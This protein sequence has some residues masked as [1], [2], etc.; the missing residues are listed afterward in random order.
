MLLVASVGL[1]DASSYLEELVL[2]ADRLE[3]ASDPY[4]YKLLH[5]REVDS[6]SVRSAA[7]GEGFLLAEAGRDDP[8]AEL[9]ATLTSFFQ[10]PSEGQEQ[11]PQCRFIAR[12][13]WLDARLGFD[14]SKLPPHACPEFD[15][16]YRTIKPD[17]LTLVFAS[18]YVNNPASMYGHTLLRIDQPD[19]V[20]SGQLVAYAINYSASTA[21][22]NGIVFAVLGISG[23]Y[24]GE[25]S[26][27]PYYDKVK[28][29][30]DLE[31]R[32]LWEYELALTGAETD[33]ILR[34][35]WEL[36]GVG[37]RYYFF[38]QNCSYRLLELLEVARPGLEFTDGF[39]LWAIPTDTVRTVLKTE[40]ML[41]QVRFRPGVATKLRHQF[42][43]MPRSERELIRA[44]AVGERASDDAA[45]SNAPADERARILE[46]AYEYLRYLT[47]AGKTPREVAAPRLRSLLVARSRVPV[48]GPLEPPPAPAVRP[49][50][51]HATARLAVSGGSWDGR[52]FRAA[53]IRAAYHGLLDPQAG[54]QENAEINFFDFEVR[55]LLED[56]TTRLEQ[57]D[58]IRIESLTPRDLFFSPMSWNVRFGLVRQ[59]TPDGESPLVT[60]LDGG[61]A[62]A[63]R[64]G[65]QTGLIAYGGWQSLLQV[66]HDLPRSWRVGAGPR[67]GLLIDWGAFGRFQLDGHGLWLLDESRPQWRVSAEHRV[68]LTRSLAFGAR[69]GRESVFDDTVVEVAATLLWYF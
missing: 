7:R 13:H 8:R 69:A 56:R 40:G 50:Q 35:A 32:N 20:G 34:H 24:L 15:Q 33:R 37:F 36:Q 53:R 14:G 21:E 51:G 11:H 1:A 4:W 63:Y 58:L 31:S 2:D 27:Q 67:I 45:V 46:V 17:R 43:R 28:D 52:P 29:Y 16:W 18:A 3:L 60:Q 61:S 55:Q 22:T 65:A 49:D 48:S 5:Y 64:P 59:R 41:R 9:E 10:P 12:Y 23:G 6:T 57:I 38:L 47:V 66:D 30:N 26:L 68:P 39:G 44:L 19:T 25:F 62:W 54:F 42:D